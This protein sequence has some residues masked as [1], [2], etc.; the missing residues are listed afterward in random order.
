MPSHPGR[1]PGEEVVAVDD[2][3]AL[4]EPHRREY[5]VPARERQLHLSGVEY[6]IV[7]FHGTHLLASQLFR[8]RDSARAALDG[9]AV[10]PGVGDDGADT[11]DPR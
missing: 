11:D 4:G 8:G 3:R 2:E 9:A 1:Q 10:L 6:E 7:K 5:K